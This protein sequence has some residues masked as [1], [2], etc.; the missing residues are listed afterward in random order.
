MN[1]TLKLHPLMLAAAIGFWGWQT[2]QWLA[3]LAAAALLCASFYV[4]LRWTLTLA[5]SYR[6]ADFCMVLALLLGAWM[7]LTYG[8]PRAVIMFFTWLPLMLLPVALMHAYGNNGSDERMNLAVLFWSVRRAANRTPERA[9]LFDPWFPYYALW[10][11]AASAANQR[12]EWFY[13]GLIALVSW[14]LVRVR[15]WSYR[16]GSWGVAFSAAVILGYGIFYTLNVTQTWLEGAVPDWISAAGSRTDP[17]R[18]TTDIGHIGK[19]KDS[20]SIVLRITTPDGR[21]PPRLL[22]RASYNAYFDAKWL[23]RGAE[24]SRVATSVNRRW[25]L[26]ANDATQRITIHDYTTKP[27]PVLTLPTGTTVIDKLDAIDMQR[28][29]MGAVQIT[30]EPGYFSYDTLY[31]GAQAIEGTPTNADTTVSPKE[32]EAFVALATELGLTPRRGDE[33]LA[34]VQQYF[35]Q[36]Y[37]YSTFQKDALFTGSPIVDFLHR[38]KSGH[39]EYFATAAVLLLRAGGIPARY[40]TGFVA[41]EKSDRENAWLVR[42]RHA[43]AWA[44]AYVNG[45][46]VDVDTTPASWLDIETAESTGLWSA[47]TDWW[48]WAHF[49][50]SRAW[51][52]STSSDERQLLMIALIV[53]L[54]FALWLAWRLWRSRR[55]SQK[56]QQN[57]IRTKS[58]RTG[59]DS[60]FYRIE[61]R[62]TERGLGR[63][64]HETT[65][66]WLARLQ[67]EA[68][69]DTQPLAEIVDLHY[70]FRFDPVGLDETQRARLKDLADRWVLNDKPTPASQPQ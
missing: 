20:D 66:D 28:N 24:F 31:V 63:R 54:P 61:Q 65:S 19:L 64:A 60:G 22:H 15:P 37:R 9:A 56:I 36:G 12:G 67:V 14:P 70:R 44:R 4:G 69:L 10:V 51:T 41:A 45:A 21:E 11:V 7:W 18:A 59:N 30:R 25:P 34:Q 46:W 1:S 23:A 55:K 53:V 16:V 2:D 29:A 13:I 50:A 52:N 57:Q 42:T 43:H 38:T 48:S 40:A 27:N 33:A 35:A 17:Y 3:A 62:L 8:N 6:V 58:L 32:R 68:K 49:R 26:T 47:I 39:C 5:Q